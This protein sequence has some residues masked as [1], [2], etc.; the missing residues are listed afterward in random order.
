MI[1]DVSIIIPAY[2]EGDSIKRT[3]DQITQFLNQQTFPFEIIVVNDGS[4]DKTGEIVEN[5]P[6]VNLIS[7]DKNQGKGAAVKAGVMAAKNNYIL[8]MDADHAIP[9]QYL[10]EFKEIDTDIVIGSKYLNQTE[11]YPLYRRVVGKVFSFLKYIITGLNIKDTQC[12]FKFF[13]RDVAKKLFGMS[14]ITGWCFDVE[15]LLLAK[16][17]NYAVKEMP[18]K[19]SDI[20]SPSQISLLNSGTQMFM[21]LLKLRLKFK[22]GDYEL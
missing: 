5:Y 8:F 15:I 20:N 22:R 19:L 2:N 17:L 10:L 1:F 12:G 16:K 7:F 18:I 21:D 11:N 3:L 14:Q 4:T 13:K 9:I 6:G